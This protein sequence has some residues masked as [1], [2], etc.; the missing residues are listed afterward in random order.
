MDELDKKLYQ[1]ASEETLKM[2]DPVQR[3]VE[4]VLSILPEKKGKS[5]IYRAWTHVVAAAACFMCVMVLVMPNVSQAYAESMSNLP[6]I[7][8]LIR[9]FTIRNYFYSDPNHEMNID[10]PGVSDP[11]GSSG[12]AAINRDV[13]QLTRELA[14]Q[15]YLDLEKIGE[16]GH[17]S[18][19]VDYDVLMSTDRWFT[20]KLSVNSIEG[21]GNVY[22]KF[23]N[24]D[25]NTGEIV[26]LSNL[27]T[28]P[29]FGQVIKENIAAQMKARMEENNTLV[30]WIKMQ[31]YGYTS[32]SITD[33]HNFYFNADGDLVI[34]FDKYEV[35]P[36]SMGNPEFVVQRSVLQHILKPEYQNISS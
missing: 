11:R 23:Y 30:Y 25:R 35:A 15:F 6:V 3:Q 24:V 19:Y 8:D 26:M 16:R 31:G 21:S 27:F 32:W 34:P 10:V 4:S 22:Y 36:G 18:I 13:D 5:R 9:V 1:M 12:A 20:L 17:G 2:P 33:D 14:N 7:G 28:T 29:D